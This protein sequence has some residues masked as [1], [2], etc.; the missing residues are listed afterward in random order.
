MRLLVLCQVR[1]QSFC[2]SCGGAFRYICWAGPGWEEEHADVFELCIWISKS[3]RL[4]GTCSN[5]PSRK[6]L[7]HLSAE[8]SV[9]VALAVDVPG[10]CGVP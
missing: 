7:G 10:F 5:P 1:E 3:A 2:F 8:L 4:N 6:Q 9:P